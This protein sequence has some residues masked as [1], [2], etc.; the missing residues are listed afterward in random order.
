MGFDMSSAFDTIR[1]STI[2]NFHDESG[3]DFLN[4]E[5]ACLNVCLHLVP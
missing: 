2:I 4:K 3:C 1:R 5:T